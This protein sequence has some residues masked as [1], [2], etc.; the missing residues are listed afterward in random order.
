VIAS[1]ILVHWFASLFVYIGLTDSNLEKEEQRMS[2]ASVPDSPVYGKPWHYSHIFAYYWVFEV[3]STVGYG[4][5][6]GSTNSE[7]WFT[8]IIEF[9]GVVFVAMLLGF[10]GKV[11]G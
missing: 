3:V 1:L 10:I 8:L 6:S 2:W 11:I 4:E 5:F 9:M 7:M